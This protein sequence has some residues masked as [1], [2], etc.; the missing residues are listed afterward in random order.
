MIVRERKNFFQNL[1]ST[2]VVIV[3]VLIALRIAILSGNRQ[4]DHAG[5]A[6]ASCSSSSTFCFLTIKQ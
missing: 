2:Y 4:S 3:V 1:F 5:L 6:P